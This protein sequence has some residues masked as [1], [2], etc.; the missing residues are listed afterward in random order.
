MPKKKKKRRIWPFLL[1]AAAAGVALT[2][3]V[4]PIRL[5]IE[6]NPDKLYQ[7]DAIEREDVNV[8]LSPLFKRGNK[9]DDFVFKKTSS[10]QYDDIEVQE[11]IF[12]KKEHIR[13]VKLDHIEAVYKVPAHDGDTF[14]EKNVSVSAV[15]K[16]GSTEDIQNFSIIGKQEVL[17]INADMVIRTEQGS[18]KLVIPF[19]TYTSLNAAYTATAYEGDIF[20]NENVSVSLSYEDGSETS[21]RVLECEGPEIIA[22]NTEYTIY[23]PFGQTQLLI[24]PVAVDYAEGDVSASGTDY[25]GNITL[26][27]VDGTDKVL[28]SEEVTFTDS[29]AIEK[30]LNQL[31]F[32]WHG[33][34]Y[35]LYVPA[36]EST[37]VSV[38][39]ST[40]KDEITA[41]L[42][43]EI[44]TDLFVTVRRIET[45]NPYFLTHVVLGDPRQLAVESAGR[46]ET[47]QTAAT[48]TKWIVG[49]NGSFFEPLMEAP[50]APCMIRN[51]QILSGNATTG[52][53]ICITT[54]G[55]LFTPPAGIS[56]NELVSA[57]VRDTLI[58][59]DPVL[60]Q[61]WNIYTE[62]STTVGGICPR[63]AVAMVKPGEYYFLTSDYGM[64]YADMQQ[65]F[66]QL[67]CQYARSLDGGSSVTLMYKEQFVNN[68]AGRS[69]YDYLYIKSKE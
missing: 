65:I 21:V 41:S 6:V 8:Y 69:V 52:N 10:D 39:E 19:E 53:E 26:R 27:Y 68:S 5:E 13:N 14:D 36:Y 61:D 1:L 25:T 7:Y 3:F 17:D 18:A 9:V 46:L 60:I 58:T 66:A 51:G 42:Y 67:G 44:D 23:T 54:E 63:T 55:A 62:G 38:A 11:T 15:Y 28:P 20:N 57:G 33:I 40:L 2:G 12:Y 4:I 45:N 49:I 29:I 48:R 32:T 56:A 64:T 30:G 34:N 24:E 35:I 37:P 59:T 22:G 16:D 50:M 43:N 31:P 47:P